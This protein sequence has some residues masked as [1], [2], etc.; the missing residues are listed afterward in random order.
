MGLHMEDPGD[1]RRDSARNDGVKCVRG[2]TG[3]AL[4]MGRALEGRGESTETGLSMK[5]VVA[6]ATGP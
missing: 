6:S 2:C 5:R 3:G 4:Y 1:A